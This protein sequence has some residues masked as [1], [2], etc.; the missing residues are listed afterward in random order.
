MSRIIRIA[1]VPEYMEGNTL[2]MIIA[3]FP[4]TVFIKIGPTQSVHS[5][6]ETTKLSQRLNIA[7]LVSLSEIKFIF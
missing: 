1:V 2:N 3:T 5:R 6:T 7:H 4:I